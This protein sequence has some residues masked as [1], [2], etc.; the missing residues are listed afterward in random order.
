MHE[1]MW[2][3]VAGDWR[4]PMEA[5]LTDVPCVASRPRW[6]YDAHPVP[7]RDAAA[8]V[9]GGAVA[10]SGQTCG[11]AKTEGVCREVLKVSVA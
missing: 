8:L 7:G 3:T 9:S 2:G 6:L 1:R 5:G 10:H 4:G 11:V